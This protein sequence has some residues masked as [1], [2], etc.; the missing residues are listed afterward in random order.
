[1]NAAQHYELTIK[2]TNTSP[3]TYTVAHHGAAMA[4]PFIAGDDSTQVQGTTA[5][6][7]DYATVTFS[8]GNTQ[9]ESLTVTVA[10]QSTASVHV[11]FTAPTTAIAGLF[12]VYSGYITFALADQASEPIV[13]VPYAGMVGD[14]NRA[15]VWSRKSPALDFFTKTQLL[16]TA[17]N[18]SSAAGLYDGSGSFIPL[19]AGAVI[20]ATLGAYMLTTASTTSRRA[21]IDLVFAGRDKSILPPSI[22]HTTSLGYAS[23]LELSLKTQRASGPYTMTF[24]P[25]QRNA[26]ADGQGV[27]AP[28]VF[29]WTG[30]VTPNATIA[31]KNIKLP[32]G[33]YQ[34]R[35]A[36]L[37]HFGRNSATAGLKSDENYDVVMSPVFNLVY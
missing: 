18:A 11:H 2:N 8:K 10:P 21:F 16:S 26:P 36:A 31:T 28:S 5:Y 34:M 7:P 1:M 15:P 3:I 33:Q 24:T 9:V 22:R 12:P 4:H 35:F 29:I 14:W 23:A 32:A 13:T 30:N 25:L 37:S 6:S 19:Q 27:H 17:A 20:N